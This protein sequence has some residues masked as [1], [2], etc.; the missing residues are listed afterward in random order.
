MIAGEYFLEKLMD[1]GIQLLCGVPDSLLAPLVSAAESSS[2]MQHIICA[3]EGGAVSLAIGHHL[4]TDRLAAIYLQNSGIG[5]ALNPL[6]SLASRDVYSVPMLLII[7]WRGKPGIPDEPQHTLQ[8]RCIQGLLDAIEIPWAELDS[9]DEKLEVLNHLVRLSRAQSRPVALLVSDRQISGPKKIPEVKSGTVRREVIRH[10]LLNSPPRTVFLATTGRTARELYELRLE[11]QLDPFDFLVIGGMGHASSISLGVALTDE[12]RSV[13]CLDGD[14]AMLM[15]LGALAIIGKLKPRNLIHLVFNNGAHE[16]VGGQP[17]VARDIDLH[18]V[19]RHL[20]YERTYRVESLNHL[21][22]DW[23]E[24]MNG[25]SLA[26][27]ELMTQIDVETPLTRPTE[28]PKELKNYF[29]EHLKI[30]TN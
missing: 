13:V 16:S 2:L 28:D 26:F 30:Q 4:A 6:V 7:G 9:R 3:N 5:N 10:I 21:S 17:T 1:S 19:A 18:E 23:H 11:L 12:S 22:I 27:V 24:I 29:T 25:T 8:G 20:G 15:H 14:G